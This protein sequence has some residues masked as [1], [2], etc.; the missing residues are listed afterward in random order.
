VDR[1]LERHAL[2][3]VLGKPAVGS[4]FACEDLEV[5]DVANVST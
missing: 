4:I 5:I 3:I 2:R 1:I